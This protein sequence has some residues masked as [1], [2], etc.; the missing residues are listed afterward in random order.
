MFFRIVISLIYLITLEIGIAASYEHNDD[1]NICTQDKE[2]E[3]SFNCYFHCI[4]EGLIDDNLSFSGKNYCDQAS[5]LKI[6]FVVSKA[7]FDLEIFPRTNSP[8]FFS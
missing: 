4:S 3:N 2:S 5:E 6:K 8:P 7:N 1:S